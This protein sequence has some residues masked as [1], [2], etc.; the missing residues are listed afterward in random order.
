MNKNWRERKKNE[1]I[2][3]RLEMGNCKNDV[4]SKFRRMK[5]MIKIC[6]LENGHKQKKIR[7]TVKMSKETKKKRQKG[8]KLKL[9]LNADRKQRTK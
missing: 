2:Y 6:N 9:K 1:E 7:E 8:L 3:S 5:K 4:Q